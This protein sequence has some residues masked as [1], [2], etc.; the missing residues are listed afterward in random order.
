VNTLEKKYKDALKSSDK[1]IVDLSDTAIKGNA[2]YGAFYI[3]W[4]RLKKGKIK[5][6]L[7]LFLNGVRLYFNSHT[8]SS[9]DGWEKENL[10]LDDLYRC[11]DKYHVTGEEMQSAVKKYVKWNILE[12]KG[13]KNCLEK[14]RN[15]GNPK[16]TI[17]FTKESSESAD[18]AKNH[19][20]FDRAIS[21]KTTFHGDNTINGVELKMKTPEDRLTVLQKEAGNLE[22][23]V[24][25][26]NNGPD[27]RVLEGKVGL[28]IRYS[29]KG[30]KG[31]PC[32][33]N[34]EEFSRQLDDTD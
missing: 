14:L 13:F 18:A 9:S 6:A 2:V 11:L 24:V 5:D 22:K 17:L 21:N 33:S 8:K 20:G 19:L 29:R 4:E 1:I 10:V 26:S 12:R 34:F 16:E 7:G 28:F 27:K 15:Y 32:I 25:I 30:R 3:P 23:A 31:E